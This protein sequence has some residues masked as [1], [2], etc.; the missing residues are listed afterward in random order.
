MN[1]KYLKLLREIKSVS[2]STISVDGKVPKVR[3]I[4]IMMV[5]DDKIYFTTARGKHFYSEMIERPIVAISGMTKEYLAIRVTGNVTK[6]D[7]K[8]VDKIFELNPMMN[9]LYGGEKRDIMEAFCIENGRGEA[10]D[11][12]TVPPDRKRFAF[13]NEKTRDC[14][15][16]IGENCIACGKCM[17]RCPEKSITNDQG[18][19]IDRSSCLECGRCY[20]VC[21]ANAI[22]LPKSL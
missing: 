21:P 13:G 22:K 19:T 9:D 5:E 14:G 10:F 18:Y 3:I 4:D 15:Y 2:F 11:L 16:E 6:V 7:R 1:N 12:S 20:E 8:Y 17:E